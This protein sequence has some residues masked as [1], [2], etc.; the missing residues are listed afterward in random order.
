M[1]LRLAIFALA[2]AFACPTALGQ[3]LMQ[4]FS[5]PEMRQAL[6]NVGSTIIAEGADGDIRYF[7]AEQTLQSTPNFLSAPLGQSVAETAAKNG[8]F[9]IAPVYRTQ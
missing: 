2:A 6:E 7:D 4:N 3:A 9:A 5:W 8:I 1:S